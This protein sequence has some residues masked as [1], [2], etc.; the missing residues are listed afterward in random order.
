MLKKI[1]I[2][3]AILLLTT[4]AWA[5]E[6][7]LQWADN[8]T[9]E[10]GFVVERRLNSDVWVEIG[11]TAANVTAFSDS[12]P[13][14]GKK[15]AYRILAF[16]AGGKSAPSNEAAITVFAAY[17]VVLKGTVLPEQ[18]ALAVLL[19]IAKGAINSELRMEVHDGDIANEGE[20]WINGNGPVQLF[21]A[22]GVAANDGVVKTISFPVPVAWWREGENSLRFVH[23]S[24]LGYEI[25]SAQVIFTVPLLA[26]SG[27]K[28]IVP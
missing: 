1:V 25:R 13:V 6:I 14:A 5:L 22:Q 10:D 3:L 2:L 17:P 21:G 9:N 8:S 27:L 12:S 24:T 15:H 20:L 16:N 26:P 28:I 23:S 4:P 19:T 11:K 7:K 18:G